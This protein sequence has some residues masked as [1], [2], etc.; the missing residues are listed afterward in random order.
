MRGEAGRVTAGKPG[1]PVPQEVLMPPGGMRLGA[2]ERWQGALYRGHVAE[3]ADVERGT[4][5]CQ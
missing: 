3:Q 2:R 5:G 4:E 1:A